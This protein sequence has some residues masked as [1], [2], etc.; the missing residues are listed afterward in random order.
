MNPRIYVD[1]PGGEP[2]WTTGLELE[3]PAV[4]ARHVQV[5]RLQPGS[6]LTVFDGQGGQWL[7]K[8]IAMTRSGAR[9]VLVRHDPVERELDLRVT[10]AVCMPA[11]DRMDDLVE[12]ATELGVFSIVPLMSE[13]SVLR[14]TGERAAKR[15]AHW[16]AVAVA[17]SEQSGRNR[18]PLVQPVQGLEALLRESGKGPHAMVRWALSLETHAVPLTRAIAHLSANHLMGASAHLIILSGPEGGLSPLE[19]AAAQS[20]GFAAVGLGPRIL[21]ADTAPLAAMAA[22]GIWADGAGPLSQAM[23]ATLGDASTA[24]GSAERTGR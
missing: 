22:L 18:V 7:S 2:V 6:E 19:Q 14:L 24:R 20:A 17:A 5:L 8:V 1:R 23:P 13:R 16:Q 10:L 9:V 11:N 12:K 21:R 4:A 3:L 15:Q